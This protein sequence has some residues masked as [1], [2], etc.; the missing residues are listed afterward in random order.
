MCFYFK[1]MWNVAIWS[2]SSMFVVGIVCL[3]WM[4][5]IISVSLQWN[6]IVVIL[7]T[8]LLPS[9]PKVAISTT[10]GAVSDRNFIN[11]TTL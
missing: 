7:S 11:M 5:I 4:K 9:S 1:D 10:S 2:D 6:G 3:S 8:I